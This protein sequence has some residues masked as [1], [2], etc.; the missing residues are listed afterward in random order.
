MVII[1]G[2]ILHRLDFGGRAARQALQVGG[3]FEED[4]QGL[5]AKLAGVQHA[6]NVLNSAEELFMP[7]AGVI[8]IHLFQV[9][10]P[11]A[12]F[13]FGPVSVIEDEPLLPLKEPGPLFNLAQCADWLAGPLIFPG[14]CQ[15][16]QGSV[17]S[18]QAVFIEGGCRLGGFTGTGWNHGWFQRP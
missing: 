9:S 17:R 5:T 12:S 1:A 11:F 13:V 6:S 15:D 14:G 8:L 4:Y 7:D 3:V 10:F 18:E 2:G 16:F